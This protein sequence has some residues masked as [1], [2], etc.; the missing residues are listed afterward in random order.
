MSSHTTTTRGTAAAKWAAFKPIG[1]ALAVGLVAGPIVTS[2][3]GFQVRTST[4]EAATRASVV[5]QQA[6]F[7]AERARGAGAATTGLAWGPRNELARQWSA[8]PGSTVVD[9][10]VMY[11]CAQKLAT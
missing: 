5:E 9:P 4:A 11:A 8:M 2:L 6:L 3:A 1:I 10:D 7:C